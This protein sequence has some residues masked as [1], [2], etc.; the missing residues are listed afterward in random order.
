MKIKIKSS[1]K[2]YVLLAALV[3]GLFH[4]SE[5]QH[6]PLFTQYMFN[7]MFINPAYA[8]SRDLLSA[9]LLYR[10]QWV[11]MDGAPKTQT[12]SIHSPIANKKIGL[13]FSIMNESIG[14]EHQTG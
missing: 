2:K 1:L 14:V 13:G 9:T 6:D 12:F 7:E 5:A 4:Q 8:G 11:G 10:D 3:G